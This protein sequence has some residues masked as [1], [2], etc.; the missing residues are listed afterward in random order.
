MNPRNDSPKTPTSALRQY[1]LASELPFLLVGATVIAGFFGYLLDGW[2][3]TKP[4]LM[5]V[6]G[7]LGFAA[8]VR[9]L[10]RRL[11]QNDDDSSHRSGS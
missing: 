5:I 1:A 6:L 7:G 11:G 9:E 3:H 8:G 10:L 4:W 2:L